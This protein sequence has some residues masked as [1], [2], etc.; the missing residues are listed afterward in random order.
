MKSNPVINPFLQV[1]L[2]KD[3]SGDYS[4]SAPKPNSGLQILKITKSEHENL[5][6]LFLDLA[7]TQ[8]DFIDVE[9]DIDDQERELL[10]NHGVLLEPQNVPDKPLFACNLVDVE[11]DSFNGDIDSLIV[12]PTFRFEPFNFANFA[13]WANEKSLSPHRAS[14]WIKQ[15]LTDIKTGFW[16][17]NGQAEIISTFKSGEKLTRE[18]EPEFLAKLISSEVLTTS[19]IAAKKEQ[20]LR[21]SLEKAKNQ[22]SQNQYVVLRELL[23]SAQMKAM[24]R[25]YRQ[26]LAG[27]FM[28]FD[29]TQSKRFYQHNEPLARHFHQNLTKIMSLVVGEEVI[30]S[31]VYVGSYINKADLTPH[32]DRAQCEFSISFQVDYLPEPENHISPWGLFLWK[33][34][35]S[36]NAPIQY[37]SNK[38]P[39]ASEAADKNTAV[40]LA[41]GDALVYK[42]R[43]LIHYRYSLPDGHQSTSLFF[44]YVPKDFAEHLH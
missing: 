27:G 41:S 36:K 38:F 37:T 17:E 23:S 24:R 30:P 25:F 26:Y 8:F 10:L 22:F 1:I 39:A 9:K 31:Y 33:P 4:L 44:H 3:E 15:P 18:I 16:L 21:E 2:A 42:G 35:F 32:T 6:E 7:R 40:Y 19:E 14:V 12:N 34:D 5:H 28:P 29:D 43:E 11:T 13:A 20:N